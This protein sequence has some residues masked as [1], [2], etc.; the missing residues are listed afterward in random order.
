M[1]AA[2]ERALEV[3]LEAQIEQMAAR[4][5]RGEEA[6]CET[7]G[8]CSMACDCAPASKHLA[9]FL[10]KEEG[11]WDVVG[12]QVRERFGDRATSPEE[13]RRMLDLISLTPSKQSVALAHELWESEPGAFGAEHVIAF[14]EAESYGGSYAKKKAKGYGK[15]D[16][17]E[18]Q[19]PGPFLAELEKRARK[20]VRAAAFLA[21][22]GDDR[23]IKTLH[24]AVKKATFE[25]GAADYL[26]ATLALKELGDKQPWA[27]AQKRVHEEVLTAL[28]EGQT[29]RARMLTLDAQYVYEAMDSPWGLQIGH[30]DHQ[31]LYHYTVGTGELA[32]ADQVFERIEKI[33]PM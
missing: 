16:Y 14:A 18:K 2:F 26:I 29:D 20:D 21:L 24:K 5:C 19:E 12:P 11:A 1:Q 15:A 13:R 17:G 8:E 3:D 9:M 7:S 33:T 32:E 4:E 28:D 23:G 22:R 31:L 25:E 6:T 30:L 10:A 27:G